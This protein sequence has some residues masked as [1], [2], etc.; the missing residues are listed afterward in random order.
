MLCCNIPVVLDR[1][2]CHYC[3]CPDHLLPTP[4]ELSWI[5]DVLLLES[6]N[7][8]RLILSDSLQNPIQTPILEPE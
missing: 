5:N 7:D 4:P 1:I 6:L 8:Y 3:S 2:W